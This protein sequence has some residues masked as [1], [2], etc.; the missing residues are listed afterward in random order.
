MCPNRNSSPVADRTAHSISFGEGNSLRELRGL[1]RDSSYRIALLQIGFDK[2]LAIAGKVPSVLTSM[3]DHH[4][5][6]DARRLKR[7][8]RRKPGVITV[9][10][11]QLVLTAAIC[12]RHSLSCA[13]FPRD[14]NV[15]VVG[16]FPGASGIVHHAPETLLYRRDV[17]GRHAELV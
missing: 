13:G 17:L 2:R 15:V 5:D 3:L 9:L 16:Q 6:G 12:E 8:I 7:R 14:G 4:D 11:L 1:Q 10:F